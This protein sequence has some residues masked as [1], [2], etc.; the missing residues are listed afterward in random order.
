M[1]ANYV[2]STTTPKETEDQIENYLLSQITEPENRIMKGPSILKK[3]FFLN[4]ETEARNIPGMR[5]LR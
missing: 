3:T 2:Q 1:R 4:P 5:N